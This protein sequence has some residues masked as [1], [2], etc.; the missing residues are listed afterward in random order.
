MSR[1]RDMGGLPVRRL[2]AA[3]V[4][5]ALSGCTAAMYGHE[6][7]GV[8]AAATA[9]ASHIGVSASGSNYAVHATF[10]R[11]LPPTIPGG[12]VAVSSGSASGV[13]LLGVLLVG[14]VDYL[15]GASGQ[16]AARSSA[17]RPIAHTCSCY[18][19][20]PEQDEQPATE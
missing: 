4:C 19:Y 20:R 13:L 9:T 17:N 14:A 3:L 15:S 6:A 11:A 1:V 2:I 18:G 7:S 12:Q 5:T 8:G 10:G 16:T